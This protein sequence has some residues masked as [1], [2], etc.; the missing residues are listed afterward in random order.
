MYAG[1]DLLDIL[2]GKVDDSLLDGWRVVF[3]YKT[4][5]AVGRL[6]CL[7]VFQS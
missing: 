3:M 1:Y 6:G 7:I 4:N 5:W 2:V